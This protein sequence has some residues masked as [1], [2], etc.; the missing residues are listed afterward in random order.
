MKKGRGWPVAISY[1]AGLE[2]KR[3]LQGDTAQET[4]DVHNGVKVDVVQ[5]Q[6]EVQKVQFQA[7]VQKRTRINAYMKQ[8]EEVSCIGL[9]VN[10]VRK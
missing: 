2:L 4:Q 3:L 6:T 9:N 5:F 10:P 7:E 8:W 1:S